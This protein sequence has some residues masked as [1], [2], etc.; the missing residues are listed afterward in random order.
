MIK[1]RRKTDFAASSQRSFQSALDRL[2]QVQVLVSHPEKIQGNRKVA[3]QTLLGSIQ[4]LRKLW[5]RQT[6]KFPGRMELAF[7]LRA[8]E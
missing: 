6:K 7:M 8:R 2:K 5:S 1:L 3:L 4:R